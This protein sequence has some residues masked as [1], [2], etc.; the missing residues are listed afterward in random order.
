LDTPPASPE[1]R[2]IRS[3]AVDQGKRGFELA[4]NEG[5]RRREAPLREPTERFQPGG[6]VPPVSQSLEAPSAK[7]ALFDSLGL[8]HEA[9]FPPAK[10]SE[11]DFSRSKS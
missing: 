6:E 5:Q 11:L 2:S 3:E 9:E 7:S 8:R 4:A 1:V 10:R